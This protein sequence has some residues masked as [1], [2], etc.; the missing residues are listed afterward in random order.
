MTKKQLEIKLEAIV[1]SIDDLKNAI[2]FED[3]DNREDYLDSIE[4]AVIS[5]QEL[6][7]IVDRDMEYAYYKSQLTDKDE[8]CNNKNR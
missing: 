6:E 3:E 8:D 7:E 2:E 5:L 4:S 1:K